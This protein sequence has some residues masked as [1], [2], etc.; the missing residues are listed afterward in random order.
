MILILLGKARSW[1]FCDHVAQYQETEKATEQQEPESWLG[2]Y[3]M[4]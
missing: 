4:S 2:I 1:P 3:K